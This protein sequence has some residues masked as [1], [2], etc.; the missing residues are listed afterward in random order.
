MPRV[1]VAY[2]RTIDA[3]NNILGRF[4]MYAVFLFMLGILAW[5]SFS[6]TVLDAPVNWAVEMAQFSLAAY[7]LLGGGYSLLHDSHV[8]MDLLYS[9]WSPRRMAFADS[10]TA[11]FLVGYLVVLLLGGLS[12]TE[13]ALTFGQK[14]YSSWGP[15][16]APVKIVMCVGVVLMALQAIAIFFRDIG[17]VIGRPIA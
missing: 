2:V 16:L 6:R 11:F 7:Y 12:S 8:R 17:K 13:Y 5:S 14:N 1:I 10:L 4:V 15:P 9:R 3:I